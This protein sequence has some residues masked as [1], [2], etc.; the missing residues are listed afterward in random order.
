[1]LVGQGLLE[2]L[3]YTNFK[4][5]GQA[6]PLCRIAVWCTMLTTWKHQDGIQ[7]LIT[8]ADVEKLKSKTN[9]PKLH[10]LGGSSKAY[11]VADKPMTFTMLP[12]ALAK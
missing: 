5:P 1:L 7:K 6:F 3:A 10:S 9:I 4:Q 2:A 11:K 8:R 12:N